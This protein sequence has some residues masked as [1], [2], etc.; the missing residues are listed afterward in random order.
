MMYH[1]N[2]CEL[3]YAFVFYICDFDNNAWQSFELV[4]GHQY[5]NNSVTCDPYNAGHMKHD[6]Q[7]L[8]YGIQMN[9]TINNKIRDHVGV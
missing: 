6:Y 8:K 4:K 1:F 3:L 5:V 9:T 2:T 7:N